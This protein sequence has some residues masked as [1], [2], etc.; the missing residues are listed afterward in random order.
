M[1]RIRNLNK[2]F[3]HAPILRGL[4]LELER[5]E[6]LA[7]LGPS[8]SGKSTFLRIIAGLE[9]PSSCE[10]FECRGTVSMMFQNYALFP[11]LNVEQNILFALHDCPKKERQARLRQLLERFAIQNIS[12]KKIDQIS[13]GQAQRVAFARA[14]A[15]GCELLLLDEPFSN[16]D[17]NLKGVLRAELKDLIKAQNIAAILVTHDINDAYSMADKIALLD[18][19]KILAL[20]SPENLYLHL[21]DKNA[22]RLIP[23]LNIIDQELDLSDAFFAWIAAQNYIFAYTQLQVGS[24]FEARVVAKEFLGAFYKLR[25]EYRSVIFHIYTPSSHPVGEKISLDFVNL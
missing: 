3:H 23:D 7:V 5:G 4:D 8:G 21:G 11:H 17:Q 25:L 22:A 16:L 12:L 19:G 24:A 14:M 1:L 2:S 13:G 20:A 18:R 9:R 6:I 15:R 10:I